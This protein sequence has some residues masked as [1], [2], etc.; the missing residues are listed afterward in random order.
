M[1]SKFKKEYAENN[2][3]YEN[4]SLVVW[5]IFVQLIKPKSLN[6]DIGKIL[7]SLVVWLGK[8]RRFGTLPN[9]NWRAGKSL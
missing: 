9:R 3:R 5:F 1:R 7:M 4:I 6:L 2:I 8:Q